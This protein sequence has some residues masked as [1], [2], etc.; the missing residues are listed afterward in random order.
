MVHC[1]PC[2]EVGLPHTSA[3]RLAYPLE[4]DSNKRWR[5]CGGLVLQ[6]STLSMWWRCDKN[7]GVILNVDIAEYICAYF[8]AAICCSASDVIVSHNIDR[9]DYVFQSKAYKSRMV[10]TLDLYRIWFRR[11]GFIALQMIHT[12]ETDDH[13]E[14]K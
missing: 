11:I 1:Y 6:Y 12:R 10:F 5:H 2:D 14:K 13:I 8:Y 4:Y 7:E 3:C 9:F